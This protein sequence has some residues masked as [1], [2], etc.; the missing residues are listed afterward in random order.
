MVLYGAHFVLH[1]RT[2][3]LMLQ[4]NPRTK[5]NNVQLQ[6][7]RYPTPRVQ[8]CRGAAVEIVVVEGVE[9]VDAVLDDLRAL[10]HLEGHARACVYPPQHV[11]ENLGTEHLG[12]RAL[13][14]HTLPSVV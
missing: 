11:V 7:K 6:A 14:Q 10:A 3:A 8:E 2:E 4:K 13:Y 1:R 5:R 9:V 12:D